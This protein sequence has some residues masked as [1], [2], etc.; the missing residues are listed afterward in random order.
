MFLSDLLKLPSERHYTDEGFLKVP[1]RIA[2]TGVQAYTAGEM[3]LADKN[4][5]DIVKVYRPEAEVFSKDSLSSFANKPITNNHP[6]ELLNAGNSRK[7]SVGMS[8]SL[9]MQDGNYVKT[10]LFVTDSE[11][12]QAVEDG[13]V[14]LSNGYT[15]DIEWISGI[16]STGEAYDAIQRNI[17]GNHIAIVERGRAGATCKIADNFITLEKEANMAKITI[18]GVDYE[19]S[20][21]AGQAVSK[22]QKRLADAEVEVEKKEGDMEEI[23][24]EKKEDEEEAKKTEDS[25]QAKLDSALSKIP[26]DAQLDSLVG[27]RTALIDN[28]R[29]LLPE[30][31]FTGKDSAAIKSEVVST[32]CPNVQMDSASAD[33][34]TARF[35]TLLEDA[36][37]GSQDSSGG[38]LDEALRKTVKVTKQDG[39]SRPMD[40]VAREK[41][42]ADS[43]DAWKTDTKAG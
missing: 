22:L 26:S 35:D 18:D 11:S 5:N 34:I 19:V 1:A 39:D 37:Q 2:R 3:G 14:E 8:D 24:K 29:T 9:V 16:T 40:V 4:P 23:K 41:M 12:I 28:A 32:L 42:M 21:Q 7:Y 36:Q 33:Y 25:L 43:R 15:S 6:P 17:K 13:K 10:M 31:E 30:M 27:E 38:V 20:D